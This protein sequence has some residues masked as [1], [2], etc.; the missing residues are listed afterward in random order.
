MRSSRLLSPV[1]ALWLAASCAPPFDPPTEAKKLLARDA[2]WAEAASAGKDV[3]KIVSY[4]SD[5]ALVV[6]LERPTGRDAS[7]EV[8]RS[9]PVLLQL[10]GV[11]T[12][13]ELLLPGTVQSASV[14]PPRLRM[15]PQQNSDPLVALRTA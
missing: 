15:C 13:Q 10:R 5:D 4:W 12:T 2:E 7:D 3:D 1:V 9:F 8:V 11:R 14:S 6:H